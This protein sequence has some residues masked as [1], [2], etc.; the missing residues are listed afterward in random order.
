[1]SGK[2]EREMTAEDFDDVAT[3]IASIAAAY[4]AVAS[5]MRERGVN[6]LSIFGVDTLEA[7][8]LIRINGPVQSAQRALL[9]AKRP[10]RLLP[11]DSK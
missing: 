8:T 11:S 6:K 9:T 1:M 5:T 10:I 4:A 2:Q 7:V 3:K